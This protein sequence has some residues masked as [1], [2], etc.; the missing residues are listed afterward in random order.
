[1]IIKSKAPSNSLYNS[2]FNTGLILMRMVSKL[3]MTAAVVKETII[4]HLK[5]ELT[6]N[7]EKGNISDKRNTMIG[8]ELNEISQYPIVFNKSMKHT[9]EDKEYYYTQIVL[10]IPDEKCRL[11]NSPTILG[12]ISGR[13]DGNLFVR[14]G[15]KVIIPGCPIQ[16]YVY[17]IGTV[18]TCFGTSC[19]YIGNNEQLMLLAVNEIMTADNNIAINTNII[20]EKKYNRNTIF[21]VEYDI[22]DNLFEAFQKKNKYTFVIGAYDNFY[23]CFIQK[24]TREAGYGF[25]ILR[26]YPQATY[27]VE[28]YKDIIIT[29]D[30]KKAYETAMPL[31]ETAHKAGIKMIEVHQY[32]IGREYFSNHVNPDNY[33][34]HSVKKLVLHY[35]PLTNMETRSDRFEYD[36]YSGNLSGYV[37]IRNN[38]GRRSQW[39]VGI[40]NRKDMFGMFIV[41]VDEEGVQHKVVEYIKT[42]IQRV[43]G[44][45]SRDDG[46]KAF[47]DYVNSMKGKTIVGDDVLSRWFVQCTKTRNQQDDS[48]VKA[49]NQM[50]DKLEQE[51]KAISNYLN[52]YDFSKSLPVPSIKMDRK[53]EKNYF[54]TLH[55]EPKNVIINTI[56][57]KRI[58]PVEMVQANVKVMIPIKKQI[59]IGEYP[60]SHF[61][62]ATTNTVELNYDKMKGEVIRDKI[63]NR[64]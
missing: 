11:L 17:S 27:K 39:D 38:R 36:D 42:M 29:Y 43:V 61:Y 26:P 37:Y 54:N 8:N 16:D 6:L 28:K 45:S 9:V 3:P 7:H 12:D 10:R 1:M 13:L 52:C 50:K 15:T 58:S 53:M 34:A 18:S 55:V 48:I 63:K 60:L 14:Q 40:R 22:C 56:N 25:Q 41:P 19:S 44:E 57:N 64:R 2:G 35:A 30:G 32:G 23:G 49:Y 33:D 4:N 46:Y 21:D 62:N 47:E 31:L 5:G 51:Y 24:N 20:T 59:V